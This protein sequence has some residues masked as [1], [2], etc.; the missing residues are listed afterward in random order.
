MEHLLI[1]LGEAFIHHGHS[2]ERDAFGPEVKPGRSP[3]SR[4]KHLVLLNLA[5]A[6]QK[7]KA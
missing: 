1:A 6:L 7:A 2:R 3:S 4:D 5:M